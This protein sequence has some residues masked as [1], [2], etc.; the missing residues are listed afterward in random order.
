[1]QM[2]VVEHPVGVP[3]R[4]SETPLKPEPGDLRNPARTHEGDLAVEV[5]AR[6]GLIGAEPDPRHQRRTGAGGDPVANGDRPWWSTCLPAI[7]VWP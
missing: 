2:L 5:R 3:A 4:L 7:L 6:A 1:M